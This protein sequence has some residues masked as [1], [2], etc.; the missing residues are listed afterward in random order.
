M[1]NAEIDAA[2]KIVLTFGAPAAED[3][4]AAAYD[5]WKASR[6]QQCSASSDERWARREASK[7]AWLI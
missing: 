2:G 6:R 4:A 1:A 5:K 3:K 7:G